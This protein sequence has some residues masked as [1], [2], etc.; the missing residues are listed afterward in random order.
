MT[1]FL[2][3]IY[4]LLLI[5]K[6]CASVER[7][8]QFVCRLA[9]EPTTNPRLNGKMAFVI[10]QKLLGFHSAKDKAVRF[11]VYLHMLCECISV[12]TDVTIGLP[13]HW[14]NLE[15]DDRRH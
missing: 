10:V 7:V 12:P 9:V 11:R 13:D 3:Q 8:V 15:Q 14:R 2:P 1:E 5:F 4:R 6:R